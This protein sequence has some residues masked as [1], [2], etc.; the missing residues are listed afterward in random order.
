MFTK[1]GEV[2]LWA[3]QRKIIAKNSAPLIATN[4][5]SFACGVIGN[6]TLNY[7]GKPLFLSQGVAPQIPISFA[8]V[9]PRVLPA[10]QFTDLR[11]CLIAGGLIVCTLSDAIVY[12]G[13]HAPHFSPPRKA[14]TT[15]EI[16]ARWERFACELWNLE[17]SYV[18]NYTAP[19]SRGDEDNSPLILPD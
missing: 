11:A 3:E 1:I 9:R 18:R 19:A 7:G 12:E 5:I 6:S 2:S 14:D 13:G 16:V 8:F 15:T 10:E 17:L 4:V